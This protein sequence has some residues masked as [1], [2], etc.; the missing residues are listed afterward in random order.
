MPAAAKKTW[1]FLCQ[2]ATANC[3][4]VQRCTNEKLLLQRLIAKTSE[5]LMQVQRKVVLT[6]PRLITEV[7]DAWLRGVLYASVSGGMNV[8]AARILGCAANDASSDEADARCGNPCHVAA[9]DKSSE[10]DVD[11]SVPAGLP[12]SSRPSTGTKAWPR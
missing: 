8:G 6:C 10:G 7:G 2:F 11:T 5:V 4:K 12:S 3:Y 1:R 9:E